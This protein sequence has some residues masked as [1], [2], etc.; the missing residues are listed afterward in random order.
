MTIQRSNF[1]KILWGLS[2]SICLLAALSGRTA[3]V[4]DADV[5][6]L[7][8]QLASRNERPRAYPESDDSPEAEYPKNYNKAAQKQVW[9]AYHKL[10]NLGPKAYPQLIEHL[11]DKRYSLT[12]DTGKV[13]SNINVGFLCRWIIEHQASPFYAIVAGDGYTT[14]KAAWDNLIIGPRGEAPWRPNY[15]RFLFSDRERARKWAT[16]SQT[17]TLRHI[18]HEA[19]EWMIAEEA[20]DT[21]TFD[22]EERTSLKSLLRELQNSQSHLESNKTFFAK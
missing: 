5:K 12:V 6:A 22:L 18:Q 19:L 21:K 2:F 14:G 8:E 13:E 17:Y 7:I 4:I 9:I 3:E 20:K 16:K 10:E 1:G 11:D 15:A